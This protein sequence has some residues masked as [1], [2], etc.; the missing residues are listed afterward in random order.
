[1]TASGILAA[2]L[3]LLLWLCANIYRMGDDA[4]D[5]KKHRLLMAMPII[6]AALLLLSIQTLTEG[7][8]PLTLLSL[9]VLLLSIGM[10]AA[11]FAELRELRKRKLLEAENAILEKQRLSQQLHSEA[12]A[13]Q[14]NEIAAMRRDIAAQA[15]TI[16]RMLSG[17]ET[18]QAKK[19]ADEFLRRSAYHSKLG[20]CENPIVDAFLYSRAEE[21]SSAGT[22]LELDVCLPSYAGISDTELITLFS[23]LLDNAAEAGESVET[24]KR[25]VRLRAAARD[26][27]LAVRM[28]NSASPKPRKHRRRVR[29]LQRGLGFSIL[30]ELTE[31]YNG[32]FSG[33]MSGPDTYLTEVNLQLE[34]GMK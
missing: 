14:E 2:G 24:G 13:A 8:L 3:T 32:S 22:A 19:T 10:D 29:E 11:L 1:M 7:V 34:R 31:R 23:N 21:L 17:G 18:E 27:W 4:A 25:F 12:L 26:G 5:M 30:S 6:Q 20:Q 15:E 16:R 9:P 33:G 28:E